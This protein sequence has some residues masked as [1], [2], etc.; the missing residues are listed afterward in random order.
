MKIE[1]K[2]IEEKQ[3]ASISYVGPVEAMGD[4]I[5]EL[6]DCLMNEGLE[7]TGPPFVVYYTSPMEVSPIEM[8]YDVGIPFQGKLKDEGK[9]RVKILPQHRVLSTLH[10][11]PYQEVGS[12]YGMMMKHIFKEG[13]EIIGVPREIYLNSPGKVPESE[14]LTEIQFPIIP[15]STMDDS[16]SS[17]EF[18]NIKQNPES[19]KIY[20]IGEVK[21]EKSKTYLEIS[22]SYLPALEKLAEFSH[23]MVFW[24]ADKF[25]SDKYR[26][27]L[28][29]T[30]PYATNKQAGIFATRSEYRPNPIALTT[31]Q[32]IKV[33]GKKGILEISSIDAFD[34]T[35]VI[36]LKPYIPF[37]DRVKEPKI[38]KWLSF[39]W[40]QWRSEY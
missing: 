32:I 1:S 28:R 7:I 3:V 33:D 11:G 25:A 4:I 17:I 20:K 29:T 24:W 10:Q 9:V 18:F 21:L 2:T 23:V 35:A 38:P 12:V 34:G 26:T 27:A 15:E 37:F 8:E 13:Y 6:I 40:P 36:D 16:D 19:Y 30:L 22:D 14:L 39:L 5:N 31:C